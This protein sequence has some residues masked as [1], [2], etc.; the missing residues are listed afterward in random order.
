VSDDLERPTASVAE[1][2]GQI[3]WKDVREFIYELGL[4]GLPAYLLSNFLLSLTGGALWLPEEWRRIILALGL[5]AGLPLFHLARIHVKRRF[6]KPTPASQSARPKNVRK[7]EQVQAARTLDARAFAQKATLRWLAFTLLAICLHTTVRM[8]TVYGWN[9]P[10]DVV[11]GAFTDRDPQ[12]AG[13]AVEVAA[14]RIKPP[15]YLDPDGPPWSGSFLFPIGFPWTK[16]GRDLVEEVRYEWADGEKVD[17]RAEALQHRAMDLIDVIRDDERT[18]LS[19]TM[20]LFVVVH[21]LVLALASVAY[22]YGYSFIE[23]LAGRLPRF[24]D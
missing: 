19:A 7:A 3:S 16:A 18:A 1:S 24:T 13:E 12:N 10:H 20:I 5:A 17:V 14:E 11:I 6:P 15:V 21:L 22:G 4:Y 2:K 8:N 9:P 23:E